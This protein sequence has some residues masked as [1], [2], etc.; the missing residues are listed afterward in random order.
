MSPAMTCSPTRFET[1]AG[2]PAS[3]SNATYTWS[4][5]DTYLALKKNRGGAEYIAYMMRKNLAK[6]Q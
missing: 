6:T 1:L 5:S 4:L 3:K 2:R